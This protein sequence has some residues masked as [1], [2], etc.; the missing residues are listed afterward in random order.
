MANDAASFVAVYCAAALLASALHAAIA[1]DRWARVSLMS[2]YWAR[3][4]RLGPEVRRRV[5]VL[6]AAVG[7]AAAALSLWAA[8]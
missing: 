8:R 7:L 2:R 5:R 1:P 4:G 3:G 6:A